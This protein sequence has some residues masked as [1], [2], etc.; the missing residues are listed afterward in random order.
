LLEL[1]DALLGHK[2]HSLLRF[3][4]GKLVHLF[5][6]TLEALLD[7]S[8]RLEKLFAFEADQAKRRDG[9]LISQLMRSR[10]LNKLAHPRSQIDRVDTQVLRQLL[11]DGQ[12]ACILRK[13][14]EILLFFQVFAL[15]FE[16]MGLFVPKFIQ[17][18]V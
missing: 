6:S 8:E 18:L 9:L 12:L 7:S 1:G 3:L 13:W 11:V 2:V 16:L 5:E 17:T 4:L 14:H 10:L 15:F